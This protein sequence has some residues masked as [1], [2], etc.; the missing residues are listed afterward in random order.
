MSFLSR[1]WNAIRTPVRYV[2]RD[3][4]GN[5]FFETRSP[6][7]PSRTK[8]TVQYDD[9]E[10]VWKYIGGGKRLPI[11]W[12][13]WLTH[14]RNNAPTLEELQADMARQ[15]RLSANVAMIEARDRAEAEEM[16]RIRQ[17]D[18]QRALEDAAE[19]RNKALL[20]EPAGKTTNPAPDVTASSTQ[21]SPPP[22]ITP[23]RADQSISSGSS[24]TTEA[25][26]VLPPTFLTPATPRKTRTSAT[27]T[28]P[29]V[30]GT[31]KSLAEQIPEQR[32]QRQGE[33]TGNVKKETPIPTWPSRPV[34]D[35]ESWTPK[36][37]RRG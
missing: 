3:L 12:S 20:Q 22:P 1:I 7:D 33:E 36:A 27:F 28:S 13:A 16:L 14:T 15:Q 35:T 17:Q 31:E 23:A 24:S 30:E 37:R 8:R 10:D 9:P 11:Q 26:K 6:N 19:S 18:A 4:E 21:A 32:V 34:S 5:K 29:S 2:G 25:T